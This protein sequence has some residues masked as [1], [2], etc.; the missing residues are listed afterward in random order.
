M[1]R[2]ATLT[3]SLLM[4]YLKKSSTSRIID[5]K[6][7][8][9]LNN[10]RRNRQL[11]EL[12]VDEQQGFCAYTEKYI[13]PIDACEVDHFDDS[14]KG[15]P[16]DDYWNWYAVLRWINLMK[17]PIEEHQPI[18]TPYSDDVPDRIVYRDGM[19][20][21]TNE[22]D[23]EAQN[24]IKLLKWNDPGLAEERHAHIERIK[25]MQDKFDGTDS[26]FAEFIK[27]KP[28]NLSFITALQAE[29]DLILT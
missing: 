23:V 18:L 6:H 12:L 5:E 24:L 15:Q 4:R 16:F 8:Y 25:W 14:K 29:L 11:R 1:Q 17:R 10:S 13:T 9:S 26:D 3:T 20:T 2:S 22:D 7:T 21:S 27:R 28:R 19:F